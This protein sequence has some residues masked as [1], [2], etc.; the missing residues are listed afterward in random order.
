MKTV[1]NVK[2]SKRLCRNYDIGY[3]ILSAYYVKDQEV[4][5]LLIKSNIR[6]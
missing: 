5:M 4:R 2:K 1:M 6:G 3:S